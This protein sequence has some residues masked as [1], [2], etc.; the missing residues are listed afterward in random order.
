MTVKAATPEAECKPLPGLCVD[1]H[2]KPST[3]GRQ[4]C[5]ECFA[6]WWAAMKQDAAK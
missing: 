3:G 2:A 5:Q 4:R 1:C 6:A